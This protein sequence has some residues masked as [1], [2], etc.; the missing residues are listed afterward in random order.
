VCAWRFTAGLRR[1]RTNAGPKGATLTFRNK[2]FPNPQGLVRLI[3]EHQGTMRVR[4][5]Q[6]V[7]IM[8]EWKTPA[9][10]LRGAEAVV[11]QLARLAQAA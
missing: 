10:R 4:P 6:T 1:S 3:T 9:E 2:R 5:D 8:R 7:V 11:S